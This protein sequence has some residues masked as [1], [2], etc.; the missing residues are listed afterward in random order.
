MGIAGAA[1][2]CKLIDEKVSD[3]ED[4]EDSLIAKSIT[5]ATITA[6]T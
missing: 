4:I 2:A 6:P 5:D 1:F 3:T